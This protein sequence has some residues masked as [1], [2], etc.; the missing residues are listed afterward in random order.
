MLLVVAGASA[1]VLWSGR[2]PVLVLPLALTGL[3]LDPTRFLPQPDMPFVHWSVGRPISDPFF[4]AA[5]L[6]W[7]IFGFTRSLYQ[8]GRPRTIGLG[9]LWI[10]VALVL[11]FLLWSA[12]ISFE[13]VQAPAAGE[14]TTPVMVEGAP[15]ALCST[16]VVQTRRPLLATA[17]LLESEWNQASVAWGMQEDTPPKVASQSRVR[18]G[19][20]TADKATTAFILWSRPIMAVLFP[21]M[22]VLGLVG[23]CPRRFVQVAV[24][25]AAA[26]ILLPAAMTLVAV[27][28]SR[29]FGLP[30][31]AVQGGSA[32]LPALGVGIVTS[33]LLVVALRAGEKGA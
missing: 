20:W 16:Q 32:G 13:Q 19:L 15:V 3:W 26:Q 23:R 11:K 14:P 5:G 31:G 17:D 18:A 22:G 28:G 10:G 7:V 25:F 12:P 2:R 21:L 6:A 33:A 9:M 30:D 29:A 1:L 27:V 4:L 24:G 8:S